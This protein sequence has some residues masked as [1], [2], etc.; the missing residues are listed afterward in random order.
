M[1]TAD[2]LHWEW[3]ARG[4]SCWFYDNSTD[5]WDWVWEKPELTTTVNWVW[6]DDTN[7]YWALDS[8]TPNAAATTETP[9]TT[10]IG[11]VTPLEAEWTIS[12]VGV[13][14][15]DSLEDD[16]Q[17]SLED[18]EDEVTALDHCYDFDYVPF[19]STYID[20]DSTAKFMTSDFGLADPAFSFLDCITSSSSDVNCI[21]QDS[22][23]CVTSSDITVADTS[24]SVNDTSSLDLTVKDIYSVNDLLALRQVTIKDAG[25]VT[26]STVKIS[27][28]CTVKDTAD[29]VTSISNCG[30]DFTDIS[31]KDNSLLLSL[32]I[33][34]MFLITGLSTAVNDIIKLL[35]RIIFTI[36][37]FVFN[38]RIS[39]GFLILCL[40]SVL[41]WTSISINAVLDTSVNS[42]RS[43][44]LLMIDSGAG[45]CVCV[46]TQLR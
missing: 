40:F 42:L 28:T 30:N 3:D 25:S 37:N 1:T 11:S 46:S 6:D 36:K 38:F 31:V 14:N 26:F 44:D 35:I 17:V 13:L 22:Y 9:V 16:V 27:Q 18:T 39:K 43:H 12:H 24:I 32:W 23:D 2:E 5:T 29:K 41:A 8:T 19:D 15:W 7:V 10:T 33:F 45:V 20:K 21:T 4:N 34:V